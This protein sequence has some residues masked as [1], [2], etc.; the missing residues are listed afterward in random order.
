MVPKRSF[1]LLY[2]INAIYSDKPDIL[3]AKE[4]GKWINY[5]AKDFIDLCN[6]VSYALHSLGVEKGD[7]ER[8][9]RFRLVADEWS[10]QTG[11]LSPTLKLKRN[12]LHNRYR[13]LIEEIFSVA[14]TEGIK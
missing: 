7:F 1:D 6:W 8:I 13:D 5:S 3:A 2:R 11:E 10:M 4:K 9:K 14:R 12:S